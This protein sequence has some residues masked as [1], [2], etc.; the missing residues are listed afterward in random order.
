MAKKP[1]T[2]VPPE[3]LKLYEILKTERGWTNGSDYNT[4]FRENKPEVPQSTL[5]RWTRAFLKNDAHS[6]TP[7]WHVRYRE[8]GSIIPEKFSAIKSGKIREER[9][10]WRAD[11]EIRYANIHDFHRPHGD[12]ALLSLSARIV[13]DFEPNVFP[14]FSDWLDMDRVTAH[15]PNPGSATI[16]LTD[17]SSKEV[18]NSLSEIEKLSL[19]TYEI[20]GKILPKS[21]T[22]LNLWGNHEQWLLRNILDLSSTS[23]IGIEF[24]SYFV[25]KLFSSFEDRGLLWVDGEKNVW[26]PVLKNF[27]VGHGH[28]S[29]STTGGTAAAYLKR[30]KYSASIAVGHTHRQE[31]V[32][33][34][35]PFSERRFAAVSGT[36][37]PVQTIYSMRDFRSHNWGFQ[38]ITHPIGSAKG[39]KLQDVVIYYEDGYYKTHANGIEYSE[40]ATIE[41]EEMMDYV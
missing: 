5:T 8:Q 12:G 19:E 15:T 26:F 4:W 16:S 18:L 10:K 7:S 32:W 35:L 2:Y 21:C 37:G 11:G 33:E 27:W 40:K 28:L 22:K 34:T 39:I 24:A 13:K 36:L 31:V 30:L 17:E 41:Y 9:D 38:L 29:R 25:D 6:V 14:V 20:F 3:I 1:E 23:P